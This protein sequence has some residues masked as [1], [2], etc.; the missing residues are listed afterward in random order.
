VFLFPFGLSAQQQAQL[1]PDDT[2]FYY[3]VQ[4]GDTLW[5]ISQKFFNDSDLWPD[6][7]GRNQELT[8]P[9]W[10]YPGDILHIFMRNGK[11]YVDKVESEPEPEPTPEAPAPTPEPEP[12][13]EP[14]YFFYSSI[15]QVGFVRNPA[16]S[17]SGT[18]FKIQDDRQMGSV[19]DTIY[20]R[21]DGSA[22]L[23]VGELFTVY[24]TDGPIA[25]PVNPKATIGTQH[26]LTGVVEI[27]RQESGYS[28]A[29][30]IRGF[31]TIEPGNR[32]MPYDNASQ[33]IYLPE[34]TP[35]ISGTI[36]REEEKALLVAE[37][38]IAFIDKGAED[39]IENGQQFIAYSQDSVKLNPKDKERTLL[40]PEELGRMIVLRTEQ[41][42]ATVLVIDSKREF[43]PGT[44]F[45]TTLD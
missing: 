9:H 17:P 2:G 34:S 5:D 40:P 14:A 19:G 42:T 20:I 41:N 7:W 21:Q 43:G 36:F 31:R 39:G 3:T 4:K 30:V 32:V 38:A 18:I 15:D 13:V 22:P 29:K 12:V 45:S 35:D 10:I 11:L 8:N 25:D 16:V 1:T 44:K 37:H 6:L 27:T 28:M 24:R 33:K 23:S 26:Y